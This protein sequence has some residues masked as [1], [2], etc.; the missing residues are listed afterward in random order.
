M[1][2]VAAPQQVKAKKPRAPKAAKAAATDAAPAPA[3][4]VKEPKAKKAP[5]KAPAPVKVDDSLTFVATSRIK[6][7]INDLKINKDV[8]QIVDIVKNARSFKTDLNQLLSD[9][10]QDLVGQFR[11]RALAAEKKRIEHNAKEGKPDSGESVASLDPYTVAE[12]A[13]SRNK[14]KFSKDSFQVIGIVM[15]KILYD[16][17]AKTMDNMLDNA[18]LS[19]ISVKYITVDKTSAL[20]PIYSS[21]KTFKSLESTPATAVVDEAESADVD[22][23]EEDK[24]TDGKINFE[25]YIRK[26]IDKVKSTDDKYL[27]LDVL[28]RICN[29]LDTIS[30]NLHVK[31]VNK[32]L[33]TTIFKIMICDQSGP[34]I[35]DKQLFEDVNTVLADLTKQ[36]EEVTAKRVAEKASA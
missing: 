1:E 22:S 19:S 20:Y 26:I 13:F 12:K 34:R 11:T 32:E 25:C 14:V 35:C 7:Y 17:I 27:V 10:Q 15:D 33:F 30:V 28:D 21:S 36:R 16:L 23:V 8:N 24:S 3:P 9:E 4:K 5:A 2:N 6:T 31:T 29:I 18:K